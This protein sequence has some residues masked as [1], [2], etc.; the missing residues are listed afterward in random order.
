MSITSVKWILK[1]FLIQGKENRI[2]D[3]IFITLNLTNEE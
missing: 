2:K 1:K 3:C